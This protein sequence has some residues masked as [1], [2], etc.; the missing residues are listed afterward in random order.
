V[1]WAEI[2]AQP[3]HLCARATRLR[4]AHSRAS[5][6]AMPGREYLLHNVRCMHLQESS[7]PLPTS[8]R[9]LRLRRSPQASFRIPGRAPMLVTVSDIT[10]QT[11]MESY[12]PQQRIPTRVAGPAR[13]LGTPSN[14]SMPTGAGHDVVVDAA[15]TPSTQAV[16]EQ[17]G[18]AP[19]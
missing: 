8:A 13:K 14:S 15:A 2:L 1:S 18:A 3:Y 5:I 16:V 9:V 11:V 6:H 10:P 7:H 19:L 4:A 17:N 12:W